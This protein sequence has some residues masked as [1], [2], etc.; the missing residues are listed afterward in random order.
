MSRPQCP[1]VCHQFTFP[2]GHMWNDHSNS[3]VV[4]KTCV[5]SSREISTLSGCEPVSPS[6][7]TD[8]SSC[9]GISCTTLPEIARH[10]G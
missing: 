10:L 4:Y 7:A 2:L 9:E 3:S 6:S 8:S 5:N 1:S